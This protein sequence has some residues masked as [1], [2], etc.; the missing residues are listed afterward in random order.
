MAREKRPQSKSDLRRMAEQKVA[1]SEP[2]VTEM[3]PAEIQRLVHELQIHQV[4]LQMQSEE[5]RRLWLESEEAWQRYQ[6]LYDFAPVGYLTLDKNGVIAET[7]ITATRLLGIDRSSLKGKRLNTYFSPRFR[8]VFQECIGNMKGGMGDCEVEVTRGDGIKFFA[9]LE[10]R[11]PNQ[12]VGN[13]H[14]HIALIDITERKKAEEA[15]RL[16][17]EIAKNLAEGIYIVGYDDHLIKYANPTL[18]EMFGYKPGEIIGKPISIVN[19]PAEKSPEET[20]KGVR[21][22][23]YKTGKWRGE[24]LNIKKDGTRFWCYANV[25][26]FNHPDYG[27]VMLA[28][29][30]DITARKQADKALSE[31][32]EQY[33]SLFKNMLN[34]YAFCKM[35]FDEDNKPVDFIYIDINDAFEKLTGLRKEDVIGKRV[36]EAIP[37]IKVS[38]PEI[39]DIYGEVASTGK[40]TAFEILIKPLDIWFAISVYSP[41]KDHFVAVFDNI[42]N[43]KLAE[44]ML[45]L[46][47]NKYAEIVE[48]ANDGIIIIQNGLVKFANTR[49]I[50]MTG[51]QPGEALGKPFL[52][53]VSPAYRPLVSERYQ[54]RI[55]GQSVPDRYEIE[56]LSRDG[57][58]IPVEIN[59][60]ISEFEGLSADLV[61]VRDITERKQAE[62]EIKERNNQLFAL[63]RVSQSLT[64]SI[65][66]NEVAKKA[67][68]TTLNVLDL[69]AGTIRSLD[70]TTRELVLLAHVGLPRELAR[71]MQAKPRMKLGQGLSGI[72]AQQLKPLVISDLQMHPNLLFNSLYDSGFSF[73]V[74]IPLSVKGEL[75]GTISCFSRRQRLFTGGDMELLSS[76]G[77]M[78]GM[79]I[80]N[81]RLFK[82]QKQRTQ[83]L[84][85]LNQVSQAMN[86]FLNLRD[87]ADVALEESLKALGLDGGIIRYLD[88]KT[89]EMVLL[90]HKGL[91]EAV[92]IDIIARPGLKL[93]RGLAG[94]L[95]SS[96]QPLVI[97]DFAS[98]PDLQLESM[99]LSGF[100]TWIG[101]PLKVK[102]RIVG[103]IAGLS[104]SRR[105]FSPA[106][107]EVLSNLGNMVGMSIANARLFEEQKQ[108]IEKLAALNQVSQIVSKS[109]DMATI[110]PLALKAT[111][112]VTGLDA[113]AIRYLDKATQELVT[114]GTYGLPPELEA[115]RNSR[116]IIKVGEGLAG[117]AAQTG[118]PQIITNLGPDPRRFYGTTYTQEFHSAA[119]FPLKVNDE[120]VGV[121]SSFSRMQRNFE[122]AD[123]DLMTSLG[124][125]VGMAIYNS[126]LFEQ[127]EHA[128]MEWR[129]TFDAMSD[130]VSIHSSDFRIL[131]ANR[132]LAEML[133]T[134]PKA[135]IG[136][137]CYKVFHG[138]D[139]PM[140]DCP[141]TCL[142]SG[143]TPKEL[144]KQEPHLGN[145]WLRINCDPVRNPQGQLVSVVHTMRDITEE[146]QRQDNLE[147]LYRLSRALSTSLDLDTVTSLALDE[148]APVVGESTSAICITLIDEQSQDQLYVAARGLYQKQLTNVRVPLTEV[149]QEIHTLFKEQRG[150][151]FLDDLYNAPA[152]L[153]RLSF[154]NEIRSAMFFPLLVRNKSIG[155]IITYN[156]DN[157][158]L[159]QAQVD[160]LIS[161]ASEIALAI[162]N[163]RLFEQTDE[164]LKHRVAELEAIM[165]SMDEGLIVVDAQRKVSYYNPAAERLLGINAIGLLTQPIGTLDQSGP[166]QTGKLKDLLKTLSFSPDFQTGKQILHF[167]VWLPEHKEIETTFFAIDKAG[168][169]F[170]RGVL[171]RDITKEREIDRMK[172]EFVSLASHE[173]RTPMTVIYGFA[174]LLLTSRGTPAE[175]HSWLERIHKETLR[176]T[177][178]V[179]DFLNITRIESGRLSIKLAAVSLQPIIAHLVTQLSSLYPSHSFNLAIPEDSLNYGLILID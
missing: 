3:P 112:N 179:D 161:C 122:P 45:R 139:T 129:E 56:I 86:L 116:P 69:D 153:K 21:E 108:H 166:T 43:R 157:K 57:K 38:N 2:K 144:I 100:Q 130:G 13:N 9:H 8:D 119:F 22:I 98:Y 170:G 142:L 55:S 64:Q 76:L 32:E 79:G 41:R 68:E 15:Q 99:R 140:D 120:I 23:I 111:L 50:H 87:V 30:S 164:A 7:N 35:L 159:P 123:L 132:A 109:L 60:S 149:R 158:P 127:L 49:L 40:P 37:G 102:D 46:S 105:T 5:A 62:L 93:D 92:A 167:E 103:M 90:S 20:A 61:L 156:K 154:W 75:V 174:E 12:Q 80:T 52:D 59:A 85:A 175:Q 67:L 135:L 17:A 150:A 177:N 18:E 95:T 33:R 4:Q 91:P 113:G 34:G 39:F 151:L 134:T 10:M 11:T 63:N 6:E 104:R 82:D 28:I 48:R 31:S 54:K 36:T 81:A 51:F 74:G 128:A 25:S 176:L 162:E 136:Q 178:I 165:A 148:I 169:H 145:R 124:N 131:R 126:R 107:I 160:F 29:H 172:T 173:L 171:L 1:S 88:E 47:E 155:M 71:E 72:A 121:I 84:I 143:Q 146:K 42:T 133:G 97:H 147:H 89:Q 58:A 16:E 115:Q 70:E 125:M 77:N 26:V 117:L 137:H 14:L 65:E 44:E 96:G 66:F 83:E 53:F 27:K 78:V 106:D 138:L 101:L 163:A 168:E 73:Y 114:I 152:T 141:L 94:K 19:A 118:Q 24:I 110:A